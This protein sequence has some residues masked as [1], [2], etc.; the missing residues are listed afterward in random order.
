[1]PQPPRL[2]GKIKK[3]RKQKKQNIIDVEYSDYPISSPNRDITPIIIAILAGFA[4]GYGVLLL[5]KIG[6]LVVMS[7]GLGWI[8]WEVWHE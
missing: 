7:L 6:A 3:V 8:V 1:M 4:M 5:G 2:K